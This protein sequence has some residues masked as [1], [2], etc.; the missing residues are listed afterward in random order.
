MDQWTKA[1]SLITKLKE[2]GFDAYIVGGAVR[3]FLLQRSIADLDIVTTAKPHDIS[4]LFTKTFQTNT[5]H[6]TILVRYEG[7]LFELTTI[8]GSS[9]EEDLKKRDLTINSLAMNEK[10]LIIDVVN[11]KHDI[12]M[13]QLASVD[14][15]ERM[16]EDPLRMLRVCRFISELGFQV[17]T[18]L[19]DTIQ[20]NHPKLKGVAVER[21]GKEWMKL[22][23]GDYYKQALS[24]LKQ[25]N[26]YLSIPGLS[27]DLQ[28]IDQLETVNSLSEDSDI[29]CWTAFCICHHTDVLSHLALSNELIR[30]IHTR[31][32]YFNQRKEQKWNKEDLYYASL[33][34]AK[35]VE[36]IRQR[37]NLS[38]CTEDVLSSYW[39][40]L[41]I[42]KR[43][44]LAINGRDLLSRTNKKQGP[45][46]K[47]ALDY[48]EKMVVTG[49]CPNE[50][51]LLFEALVEVEL[52]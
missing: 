33:D 18:N 23:K 28:T 37:F 5:V 14:P 39:M 31:L 49:Q 12:A 19:F 13:K 41:P 17:E 48:A 45:W 2:S 6:Q 10:G 40:S 8:R 20:T 50:T 32:H 7:L 36:T 21:V 38:Y 9:I 52:C 29:V 24:F 25:T 35:D 27:L 22:L 42:H 30:A 26:V 1:K 15:F 44:E 46:L 3:D 47:K 43:S 11:G 16:L 34:V 51:N 4:N